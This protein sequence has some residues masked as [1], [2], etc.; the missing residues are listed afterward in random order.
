LVQ[1]KHVH[2]KLSVKRNWYVDKAFF[3][4]KKI[5][6]FCWKYKFVVP[7]ITK[8]DREQKK[9]CLYRLHKNEDEILSVDCSIPLLDG[10]KYHSSHK[11][12]LVRKLKWLVMGPSQIFLLLGSGYSHLRVWKIFPKNI[13]FF[14][15]WSKK[16]WSG[17]VEKYPGWPLIYCRSELC[18]GLAGSAHGIST[19]WPLN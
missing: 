15:F 17:R 7:T 2:W 6:T 8:S 11:V 3:P 9:V 12:F 5:G 18:S 16:I 14:G 19:I 1:S 4:T 13:N 10:L